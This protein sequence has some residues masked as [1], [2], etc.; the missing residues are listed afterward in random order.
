M[1]PAE[2]AAL[3]A[4]SFETPRPWSEAEFGELLDTPGCFLVTA[5]GGFA[6]GRVVEDEAELL[7]LAVAP[8]TRRLG[9]G[10]R[11]LSAFEDTAR[12]RGA[13]SAFLEVS[14]SNDPAIALYLSQGYSGTGRRRSYYRAPDGTRIDALVF[15]RPLA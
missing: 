12:A 11:L 4:A 2:L 7:T 14:A 1:T 3:H 5:P 8:E 15:T 10:R 9:I 13:A 6:L